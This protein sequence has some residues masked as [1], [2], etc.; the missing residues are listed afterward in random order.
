[1]IDQESLNA[2]FWVAAVGSVVGSTIATFTALM[3]FGL[4]WFGTADVKQGRNGK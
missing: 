4:L 2:V 1:M 3:Y